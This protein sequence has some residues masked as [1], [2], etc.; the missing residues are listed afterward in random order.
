[1]TGSFGKLWLR[2]RQHPRRAWI[3]LGGLLLAGGIFV[4][5]AYGWSRSHLTDARLALQRHDFYE[6]RHH[7]DRSLRGWPWNADAKLLAARTARC[8]D[9]YGDAERFLTEYERVRG[10]TAESRFEWTLLGA[11]QGDFAGQKQALQKRVERKDLDSVL[12]LEAL[13]KGFYCT[14]DGQMMLHCLDMVLKVEPENL[15]ALLWR[16]KGLEA[17]GKLDETLAAYQR[18]SEQVPDSEVARLGLAE[19][20]NRL[21]RPREAIYHFELVRQ[22]HPDN[23]EALLGLARCRFDAHEPDESARLLDTLLVARPDHVPGLVERG[24]LAVRRD[25]PADAERWLSRVT[26]VAPWHREAHQLLLLC[27]EAQG[28]SDEARRVREHI[29]EHDESDMEMVRLGKRFRADP[30]DPAVRYEIGCWALKN[31]D[32]KNG[33]GWLCT[34][35]LADANHGPAHAALADLFER[36]G[37]PRRAAWHRSQARQ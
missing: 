16:A 30:R 2:L 7:L 3:V 18:A 5:G 8:Q 32:E 10:E 13:A 20:L 34:A 24:R 29:R 31:G 28:R 9:A 15:P 19:A 23:P 37:Q 4:L 11:Q 35:L 25:Q 17:L 14:H 36:T 21:G 12:I 22:R 6:A 33:I 26:T 1:M 27:L